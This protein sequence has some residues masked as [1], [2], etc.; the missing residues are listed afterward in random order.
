MIQNVISL[1]C[2]DSSFKSLGQGTIK[3]AGIV[4]D[5]WVDDAQAVRIN[6]NVAIN[7]TIN[8]LLHFTYFGFCDDT[9]FWLKKEEKKSSSIDKLNS[10]VISYAKNA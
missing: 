3:L 1:S 4:G 9:L 8:D 10:Y 7:R 6:A 5:K 2:P